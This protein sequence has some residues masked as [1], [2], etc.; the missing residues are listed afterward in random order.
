[1]TTRREQASAVVFSILMIVSMV[2]GSVAFGGLAAADGSGIVAN[3]DADTGQLFETGPGSEQ[4]AT[5]GSNET[6]TQTEP[7]R[8]SSDDADTDGSDTENQT[9]DGTDTNSTNSTGTDESPSGNETVPDSDKNDSDS[10][11]DS[12]AEVN[13][14]TDGNSSSTGD[15]S[16]G[17][18]TTSTEGDPDENG[19][20]N[21]SANTANSSVQSLNGTT[22]TDGNATTADTGSGSTYVDIGVTELAG[23][24][25]RNDPYEISNASELQAMDDDLSA[26]Y[27]LVDDIDA[28]DTAQ[29]NSGSGFDPVAGGNN[30]FRGSFDGNGHI[31]SGLT[32]DRPG[33]NEVG[34]FVENEGTITNISLVELTING[35]NNVGGLAAYNWVGGTIQ[36]AA[37]SGTVTGDSFVGGL[38][39]TA[40]GDS[41]MTNAAASVDVTAGNELGG[42]VGINA[43]NIQNAR[44]SGEVVVSI[45]RVSISGVGGFVGDNQGV[46]RNATASGNVTGENAPTRRDVGG[47]AGENRGTIQTAKASG[48]VIGEENV[49]GLVGYNADVGTIRDTFA[50]G[51][52]TGENN[53]AGLAGRTPGTIQDSYWDEQ[54]TG[55][56]FSPTGSATGL[57]TAEMQGVR[58]ASNMGALD[59]QNTWTATESYP[60]LRV[61]FE[62]KESGDNIVQI[63]IDPRDLPG[64]GTKDDPYEISNASELQAMEDNLSANYTLV[65]DID[66]SNTSQWNDGSGFDP[67]GSS[68]E[69]S[70]FSGSLNGAGNTIV[71]LSIHRDSSGLF[72]S[73]TSEAEVRDLTLKKVSVTAEGRSGALVGNNV[74]T[75]QNVSVTGEVTGEYDIGGLVGFNA[76][77][78]NA[79]SADVQIRA[80]D[81]AGGLVGLN[82]AY[83]TIHHSSATGTVNG[84]RNTGGL[85]G[86]N[87][88][89]TA[90]VTADVRVN[91][92]KNVGG[93]AGY[94][95]GEIR[96]A[97]TSGSVNGSDAVGG[98]VGGNGNTGTISNA[99]T[100]ASVTGIT[101]VGGVAGV[102]SDIIRD[103]FAA[104]P[105]TGSNQVG[106][107][108]ANKSRFGD[109][110]VRD[111]YWD[112]TVTGQSTSVG[113]A[114]GL[115]TDKMT[116]EA[117][118]ENM[119]NLHFGE[120]WV[121]NPDDY[122]VLVWQNDRD[123]TAGGDDDSRKGTTFV[124]LSAS[125][126]PGDGT[127]N[128]PYELSNASELQAM[129]DNL[130]AQ[131]EIVS[132]IDASNTSDWNN[133]KGFDP[134]GSAEANEGFSGTLNGSNHEISDLTIDRPTESPVGLF[135]EISHDAA[136]RNVSV[137]GTVTGSEENGRY[138]AVGGLAGRN[139]GLITNASAA[140]RVTGSAGV[141]GLGGRNTFGADVT[142]SFATGDV[143][144][145][146]FVGG[147]V[148]ANYEGGRTKYTYATGNVTGSENVGGLVGRSIYV[149]V[150]NGSYATGN[151]TGTENVGGLVGDNTD[152]DIVRSYA[153]GPVSGDAN[154]GGL[155]G[156]NASEATVSGSYWDLDS[157]GISTSAGGGTEFR[158]SEMQGEAARTNMTGFDFDTTWQTRPDDYPT[159]IALQRQ[160]APPQTPDQPET[161]EAAFTLPAQ[162]TASSRLNTSLSDGTRP[163]VVATNVTS[164]V[165]GAIV[166]VY[167]VFQGA[168]RVAG[169]RETTATETTGDSVT[170]PLKNTSGLPG[171]H[172]AVFL[173]EST[174]NSTNPSPGDILPIQ[175]EEEALATQPYDQTGSSYQTIYDGEI[176]ITDQQFTGS[177]TEI[178][179][180]RS[181]L[182]PDA[183][184]GY[185]VVLHDQSQA[186]SAPVG[187][188]IG[189]SQVLNGTQSTLSITLNEGTKI[190][191]TRDVVAMLHFAANE[192]PGQAIPNA[193]EDNGFVGGNVAERATITIAQSDD[194][195]EV[196][197]D[198][199]DLAGNGTEADPYEISNASELQAMEHNLDANYTLVTDLD[200]SNTAQWNNGTGFDPVGEYRNE[201]TGSFDGTNHTITGLT[202][203]RPDQNDTGL[204]G[205]NSGTL[206]EITLANVSVTGGQ[207]VG[208]LAG[209]NFKGT[210][211]N[212]KVSGS[213]NGTRPVGGLVGLNTDNTD[214]TV[215]NA[216]ATGSVNGSDDVG[217][218]VGDNK[219]T[220]RNATVTGSVNGGDDVGGLAGDSSGIIQNTTASGS[221]NGNEEVGGLV[222][223]NEGGI[224]ENVSASGN[225]NGSVEYAGGLVG[226]NDGPIQNATASGNV[227][228]NQGA[229]GL[230]GNNDANV[231]VTAATAS[232]SVNGS[233][234]VGGLIGL[235]EGIIAAS[236]AVGNVSG[237]R[238]VGGLVGSNDGKE[239]DSGTITRSTASGE[240]TGTDIVGGLV[241]VNSGEV[242][243]ATASGNV[244][245][246]E[247]VGGL[248]GYNNEGT[249]GDTFATAR[250]TGSDDV[251]GLVGLNTSKETIRDS[252]WDEQVTGQATSDG[253]AVGLTTAEMT[254]EAA[255]T[256]MSGLDFETAWRVTDG[257]PELR[258]S[259]RDDSDGGDTS[260]LVPF[261]ETTKP[262]ETTPPSLAGKFRVEQSVAENTTIE[263][264]QNS[265]TE[266]SINITAPDG[267]ENVTFYLQERAISASQD[268]DDVRM[269]LD[270][271]RREFTIIE[272]AGPGNSPWI[273]FTVPEFSTRTVTFTTESDS[274]DAAPSITAPGNATYDPSSPLT[275]G[276]SHNATGVIDDSDVAIRIVNVTAGNDTQVA[277]NNSVSV[278]GRAN[279]TIPAD[280]LSGDVTIETQLYNVSSETVVEADVVSFSSTIQSTLTVNNSD[281]DTYNSI[282]AAVDNAT[283]GDKIEIRSGTYR[284]TMALDKNVTVTAVDGATLNGSTLGGVGSDPVGY[285]DESNYTYP[286]GNRSDFTTG[287][288]I[289]DTVYPT[290]SGLT[291]TDYTIGVNASGTTATWTVRN[292]TITNT[293]AVG[294][295]ALESEGNWLVQNSSVSKTGDGNSSTNNPGIDVRGSSGDWRLHNSTVENIDAERSS[296]GANTDGIEAFGSAGNWTIRNTTVRNIAQLGIDGSYT[297]GDW[298]VQESHVAVVQ[299]AGIGAGN[300]RGNAT[301]RDTTIRNVSGQLGGIYI[302]NASQPWL[303]DNVVIE[304]APA[305]FVATESRTNWTVQDSHISETE[306]GVRGSQS[307]GAWIITNTTI[308]NNSEGVVAENST[309]AWTISE[310]RILNNER[311]GVTIGNSTS[312]D[313][314][315]LHENTITSNQNAGL[316]HNGT[317]QV[318]ATRN[319]WGAAD[320]PS[321]DFTGSGEK[322]FG[323]VTVQPFYTDANLTTLS[324]EQDD[325]SSGD[326]DDST[327][328][329]DG[330]D[331]GGS[332]D[333]PTF[334][335][336]GW[337]PQ[338]PTVTT[339]ETITVTATIENVGGAGGTQ[340]VEYRI[341][342]TPMASKTVTLSTGENTTV[343]F[344]EIEIDN[345]AADDYDH[346]V[347]TENDSQTGT[348]TVEADTGGGTGE[349]DDGGTDDSTPGFG[350]VASLLALV[351]FVLITRRERD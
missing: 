54:A 271:Q 215:Q 142:H 292:T 190:D 57:T 23:S 127:Q 192:S 118:R 219:G 59:F 26:H 204:F 76:G 199:S 111:S 178:T 86:F 81:G 318:N 180:N 164:N 63:D 107:L 8:N 272:D 293:S 273:A 153:V 286:I 35:R 311:N 67:V 265:S 16:V 220:I 255:R 65:T 168:D 69:I 70:G 12:P 116:G 25:T 302:R 100:T 267:S 229:G 245:G 159:L 281:P 102:N 295:N 238:K 266:Y 184:S 90:Y 279:T 248:V 131:Y 252:Y 149:S 247:Y 108:L 1:V 128:N 126:L 253:N 231:T 284:E 186:G 300:P 230:V 5:A 223:V 337:S 161:Q 227:N 163:A 121:T 283:D 217:G 49:G 135:G 261:P 262:D 336:S 92:T 254:G 141:G 45:S 51:S 24:G 309:G 130:S 206:T 175:A 10:T 246:M 20:I 339:G 349:G 222:G 214:S 306:Y 171:Q 132:D 250:V 58:A 97:T 146:R 28:S 350:S 201:F 123:G 301:V 169:V 157:T 151:V 13:E 77:I 278:E 195:T 299:A 235:N 321:G 6:T 305:G 83:G 314:L 109:P 44:A 96:L 167:E 313:G 136:V 14:T 106:G 47:F 33:E 48:D 274:G 263:L 122:P 22:A 27:E 46:I 134:I 269:L 172:Y 249:I 236:T 114:T 147:L 71:N 329:G 143:S 323:N 31:I 66:A 4:N 177:T 289:A 113:N 18:N 21:D 11:S 205:V 87:D 89:R 322:V 152:S 117:A 61:F 64:D 228:G 39:G 139:S 103:T 145:T 105:V 34:L 287:I 317:G 221:V 78:I 348:L 347:F 101:R 193:D 218:L 148:G 308:I 185:V 110:I 17:T 197:V 174:L 2:A 335:I 344:T 324:S 330:T 115:P 303:I 237:S 37:V 208:G 232:G 345:R 73:L 343:E 327:D 43:G 29:W 79:S 268:I 251:G 82:Y 224:V 30:M 325:G 188:P 19:S 351:A 241:G 244:S 209:A 42:L 256:N 331:G 234:Q 95:N 297:S 285:V 53:V 264:L 340:T 104:G 72:S 155:V 68:S 203:N 150:V 15:G 346:G 290:V 239:T 75:V 243:N 99:S 94:N 210:I 307:A 225:V 137:S 316:L 207:W 198:P 259:E 213:V 120:I 50:V 282:Q 160:T 88:N 242:R 310:S 298:T 84:T 158:T 133:G 56:V 62:P 138:D 55:Q 319:W 312:G 276:T 60:A 98:L 277:L 260:E 40:T 154:T 85:V 9:T 112:E 41:T 166:V 189:A 257:Y 74:G 328:G 196:D 304:N 170:V 326:D 162:A 296:A 294:I 176:N 338:T 173:N 288:S 258:V 320:G 93:L 226:F 216:S 342:G 341:N 52:V 191:T 280:R 240:V 194:A 182:Q 334:T 144:G 200:A 275:I 36:D 315:I 124:N 291:I 156:N 119:T 91:G 233:D 32:I 129:E 3:D 140:V 212:A 202:I 125:E 270:G 80:K 7:T 332:T 38:V 179:V 181:S 211:Q 333:A 187:P 165:D 183:P